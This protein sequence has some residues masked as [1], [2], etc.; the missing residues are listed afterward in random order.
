MACVWD[1][2]KNLYVT[3]KKYNYCLHYIYSVKHA[4]WILTR[5]RFLWLKGNLATEQQETQE[6]ILKIIIRIMW[7]VLQQRFTGLGHLKCYDPNIWS[8][9]A[10]CVAPGYHESVSSWTNII[11]MQMISLATHLIPQLPTITQPPTYW[12]RQTAKGCSR[13]ETKNL[14]KCISLWPLKLGVKEVSLNRFI[15]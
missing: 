8:V 14:Y 4:Q 6:N 5:N 9:V 12:P 2:W 13:I 7:R 11:S 3:D 15:N 1:W 10:P